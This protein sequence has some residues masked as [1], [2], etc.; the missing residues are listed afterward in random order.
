MSQPYSDEIAQAIAAARERSNTTPVDALRIPLPD[1]G[2]VRSHFSVLGEPLRLQAAAWAAYVGRFLHVPLSHEQVMNGFHGEIDTWAMGDITFLESRTDPVVHARTLAK[3]SVDTQRDFVFHVAVDGII[4]TT[5]GGRRPT[6]ATQYVPSILAL[7]LGQPMHMIRPS[8]ARVMAFFVPR[9]TVEAF[10]P[11]AGRLH[12]RLLVYD[13]P[14]TRLLGAEIALLGARMPDLEGP[15]SH[16][17]VRRCAHLIVEAFARQAGAETSDRALARAALLSQVR[18]HVHDNLHQADLSPDSVLRAFTVPRPTL[19]RMFEAEGGLAAYIRNCRL[20]E[21]ANE[22]V[23]SPHKPV[24]DIADE[25]HFGSHS[26]FTRA[27]RRDHGRSPLEFRAL[28]RDML[29]L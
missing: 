24:M 2:T 4:E 18:R 20:R 25:L 11:D 29:R 3:I 27:F 10:V 1:G 15:E 21:A 14:R 6:R 23:D 28:G 9:A 22:L 13:T 26:D 16:A 19:Y 12:G 8:W 7:D 5:T 17:L